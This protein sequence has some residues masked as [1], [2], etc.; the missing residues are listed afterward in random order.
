MKPVDPSNDTLIFQQLDLDFYEGPPMKE[1]LTSSQK[2]PI[3]RLYGVNESGNSILAHLYGYVPYLYCT[4]PTGTKPG[5]LHRFIEAL[6]HAVRHEVK[7]KDVPERVVLDMKLVTKENVYGFHG[8]RKSQFLCIELVLPKY[9]TPCKRII[10][11]GFEFPG[12][13]M[14]GY[15]TFESNIDFEIRFMADFNI[16]GCNWI[17]I[18][19]GMYKGMNCHSMGLLECN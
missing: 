9:I 6:N 5:E 11:T 3:F 10:E 16:V 1:S 8:N 13:G 12:H 19:A 17:E 18:P 4:A 2:V 15:Q 14:Q 7:Q